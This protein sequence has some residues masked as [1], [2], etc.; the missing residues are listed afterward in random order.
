ML[1]CMCGNE[2]S[3]SGQPSVRCVGMILLGAVV[4]YLAW[5][6]V[7]EKRILGNPLPPWPA[8]GPIPPLHLGTMF[9]LT[10]TII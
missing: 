10:P 2:T 7:V 1:G 9:S 4:G 8:I 5:N 3:D 6:E